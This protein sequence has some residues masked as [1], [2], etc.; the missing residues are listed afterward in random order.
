MRLLRRCWCGILNVLAANAQTELR[1]AGS[2]TVYPVARAW[3]ELAELQAAYNLTLEGGGSSS[4]AMRVCTDSPQRVDIGCM[5]RQWKSKEALLLDDGYTY[6]CVSTKKRVTQLQV[7]I[8]GIAVVVSKNSAGHD[9]LTSSEMG[10]LTAAQ[11]RWMFS[12][13]TNRQLA[14]AGLDM[15]S[16]VPNDDGDTVKE[17]S[18]LGS[19]CPE[20]PINVYG[21]GEQSGTFEFFQEAVLCDSDNCPEPEHFSFCDPNVT[22][23]LEHASPEQLESAVRQRQRPLNCYMASETDET[24]LTWTLADPG[25]VAFFGF[26]Y[27]VQNAARL[28]VVRIADDKK[29]GVADT[30]DAKVEPSPYSIVDGSYDLFRRA[31]YM[32]VDNA[33]WDRSYS[34]L[35]AGFSQAGQRMVRETG[36]VAINA[37]LAKKMWQRIQQQGNHEADYVPLRPSICWNGSELIEEPYQNQWGNPK[38]RYLCMPCV[39]GSF[40]LL[41][42]PSR[43]VPCPAGSAAPRL[44]QS[45]CQVCRPGEFSSEGASN[46]TACDRNS[47]AGSA[48]AASCDTCKAGYFT[49]APGSSECTLCEQGKFR[50]EEDEDCIECGGPLTTRVIPAVGPGDCVCKEGLYRNSDGVCEQCPGGMSCAVG[51]D[52]ANWNSTRAHPVLKP[53]FYATH[54]EPL[55]AFQCLRYD[56]CPG[57]EPESCNGGPGTGQTRMT[58]FGLWSEHFRQVARLNVQSCSI[59]W[60]GSR[61][62]KHVHRSSSSRGAGLNRDGRLWVRF[63]RGFEGEAS[64]SSARSGAR[65]PR[66]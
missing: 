52:V 39:P 50:R 10:G 42:T 22:A 53:G 23:D 41:N 58:E 38:I 49:K 12:T 55:S 61:A 47:A 9:C 62:F 34:Y 40:K 51:S 37:N 64:V 21:P 30:Q 4:G 32:N 27:Y 7:G 15:A 1:I 31:L 26:A 19:H 46:C 66:P 56:V 33:R 24:I 54:A 11:L 36:Y 29:M 17:W 2:S 6:E 59:I 63:V 45:L 35:A 3:S 20:V 43:C 16:V 25:G 60:W 18:D 28:T 48:G 13:W 44:G 65:V 57:G 5:S 14:D 8:D